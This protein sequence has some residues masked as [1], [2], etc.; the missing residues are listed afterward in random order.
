MIKAGESFYLL[1]TVR[2]VKR[3]IAL[4]SSDICEGTIVYAMASHYPDVGGSPDVQFCDANDTDVYT[5][6]TLLDD[7]EVPDVWRG[8]KPLPTKTLQALLAVAL[9]SGMAKAHKELVK[10]QLAHIR[11]EER[12]SLPSPR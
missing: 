6:E 3:F 7:K 1:D 2:H 9:H 8:K 4:T 11:R 5:L 12:L 10:K